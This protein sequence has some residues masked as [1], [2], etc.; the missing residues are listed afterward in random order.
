[1]KFSYLG[2][3]LLPGETVSDSSPTAAFRHFDYYLVRGSLQFSPCL[4]SLC[5]VTNMY[6][7]CSSKI[8]TSSSEVQPKTLAFF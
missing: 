2:N 5:P 6:G 4:V 1:M 3:D 7:D 8:L